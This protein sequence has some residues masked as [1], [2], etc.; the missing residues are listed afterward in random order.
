LTQDLLK[1]IHEQLDIIWAEAGAWPE[2]IGAMSQSLFID[3]SEKEDNKNSIRW[4][5]LPGLC[6]W[7]AGGDP[8]WANDLTAAWYLLYCAADLMDSVQDN[9]E[10]DPWW[11]DWGSEYALSVASGLFFSA[12]LMVNNLYKK[13]VTKK[14]AALVIEDFYEGFLVM[15]SGQH[16]DLV[17]AEPTL[18]QFWNVISTKSGSFFS[19][20]CRCG[21]QLADGEPHRLEGYHKYGYHLG[22]LIQILDDLE[23]W[24]LLQRHGEGPNL[25][26]LRQSLPVLYALEVYPPSVRKRLRYCLRSSGQHQEILDELLQLINESGAVLYIETEVERQRESALAGLGQA[27]PQAPAA[28]MLISLLDSLNRT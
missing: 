14:K 4:A 19:L 17:Y 28:Q 10:P 26:K 25:S 2:F 8:S 7:A 13:E 22:V 6:C 1:Q 23:D 5:R 24:S 11:S 21:A 12:S 3:D 20:A 18:E 15:S 27:A 9:D 16:M